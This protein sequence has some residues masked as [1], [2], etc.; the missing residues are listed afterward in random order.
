MCVCKCASACVRV[1][2][3]H[4]YWFVFWHRLLT[5]MADYS[6][7]NV[8]FHLVIG[9]ICFKQHNVPGQ[10]KQWKQNTTKI[11][12]HIQTILYKHNTFLKPYCKYIYSLP[13]PTSPSTV[14]K[15]ISPA[16]PRSLLCLKPNQRSDTKAERPLA[17]CL[18]RVTLTTRRASSRI[19]FWEMFLSDRIPSVDE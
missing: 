11:D 9:K 14:A 6:M 10:H 16:R 2:I 17:T 12:H 13:V 19:L 5:M 15:W 3:Q 18:Q 1:S 4:C 7:L 8:E